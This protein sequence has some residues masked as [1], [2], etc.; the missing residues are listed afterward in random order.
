MF[1]DN[2]FIIWQGISVNRHTYSLIL[3]RKIIL[4]INECLKCPGNFYNKELRLC[5]DEILY[6]Y[7]KDESVC[8]RY[9]EG[10]IKYSILYP[11]NKED[12]IKDKEV[13]K[14]SKIIVDKEIKN[15]EVEKVKEIKSKNNEIKIVDSYF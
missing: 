6:V 3:K 7:K 1:A 13:I 9:S 14:E 11:N 5:S 12:D 15:V 10:S 8:C 2:S 4:L